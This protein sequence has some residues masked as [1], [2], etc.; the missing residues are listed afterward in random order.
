MSVL[1]THILHK[2]PL[3][4]SSFLNT[5]AQ[6]TKNWNVTSHYELWLLFDTFS[7]QEIQGK[8]IYTNY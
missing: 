4:L 2:S 3:D 1:H 5:V 7:Y 8:I 6:Y